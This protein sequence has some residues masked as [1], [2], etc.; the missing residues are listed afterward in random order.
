MQEKC[1]L[2]AVG[3][4]LFKMKRQ[5]VHHIPATGQIVVCVE[6]TLKPQS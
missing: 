3:D 4:K 5:Y 2:C 1:S 6:A